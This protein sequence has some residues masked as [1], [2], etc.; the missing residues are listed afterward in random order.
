MF[1]TFNYN[2]DDPVLDIDL[3]AIVGDEIIPCPLDPGHPGSGWY[4]TNDLV[5]KLRSAK[6][7]DVS[8]TW[9][10]DHIVS[11]RVATLFKKYG[12]TGYSIRKVDVRLS[13]SALARGA[14]AP[15]LWEFKVGGWGGIAPESSGIKLVTNCPACCYTHYTPFTDA[16]K[17]IDQS[18]WDGSDFF[19]VWPMPR[20]IFITERVKSLVLSASF[21][22][23][24]MGSVGGLRCDK[25]GFSPGKLRD[26]MSRERAKK[27]G[28]HLG[29]D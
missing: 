29:I 11:D 18:Q 2:R 17:L 27:L 15:K 24:E 19:F 5:I 20:R 9:H 3:D 14:I 6:V 1:Y 13:K 26:H 22:G 7:R 25:W 12:F 23:V 21:T 8:S 4:R 16:D 28:G 10:N